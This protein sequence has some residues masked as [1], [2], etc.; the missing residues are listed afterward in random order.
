MKLLITAA[1]VLLPA[2][3]E[4][5]V[6]KAG[7]PEFASETLHYNINWPSGLSL[8]EAQL[9]AN[10][11][12]SGW[13][14]AFQL[15]A[16][17]P[18]FT[19]ADRFQ[20]TASE[21]FCSSKFQKDFT[22]GKRKSKETITFD[23]AH[24]TATRQTEGGGKSELTT[25]ACARDALSYLYYVRRELSQGRIPA[26]QPV[27]YG[28]PYQIRLEYAGSQRI[29]VGDSPVEADRMV[30][31]L[32]GPASEHSFEI[33]FARDAMRTPLLIRVPLP[34]ASFTMELVR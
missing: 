9:S 7:G 27:F 6:A 23:A 26:S 20:S 12:G 1:A 16:G 28:A 14:L 31:N 19:V 8:G 22:H 2:F 25:P 4:Q 21:E 34:L 29:K 15:D 33:F 3:A 24:S 18:G 32:K 5:P 13:S 10:K 11:G 30:A 17:I